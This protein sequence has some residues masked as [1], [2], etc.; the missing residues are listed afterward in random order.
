[1]NYQNWSFQWLELYVKPTVKERTYLR[2]KES[3]NLHILPLL[4]QYEL[5]D[6]S[7]LIL[8]KS[9]NYLLEKGNNKTNLGLSANSV[10]TIITII[11]SSLKTA[12]LCDLLPSYNANKIKRPKLIAKS[13][14]CFSLNEQRKIE[15]YIFKEK[16]IKYYGIILCF[17]TGLR[18][19]ELLALK[20]TDISFTNHSLLINNSCYEKSIN[21]IFTKILDKPKSPS[22]IR[23]IP[24]PNTL[25]TLLKEIK[26]TTSCDFV[27]SYKE[28]PINIRTY[29][30]NFESLLLKLK[31]PHRGFHAI[32]H[33]FATRALE[34]GMDVKTLA[35][36]LGHKNVN[37]TL[38]C[39][40]HSL[41][42]HK[43]LMMNKV[44]K[45][46]ISPINN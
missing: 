18:I 31:I 17:Y 6:I 7:P 24:L 42:E 25:I 27:I 38:N 41:Y 8:Q 34:C 33:T 43:K 9:I 19:G 5:V 37:I 1:M 15:Q 13:I 46:F 11:Q 36:I 4:G 35:E 22:A 45:L 26:K 44:S 40:V 30:K 16:K 12:Y 29:Q 39:Y 20:W 3:L 32:R 28:K 2:Y 21:G 10:N 14:E 23:I